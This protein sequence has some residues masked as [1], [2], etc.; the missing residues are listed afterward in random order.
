M[1]SFNVGNLGERFPYEVEEVFR[2]HEVCDFST[3]SGTGLEGSSPVRIVLMEGTLVMCRTAI[4]T[5]EIWRTQLGDIQSDRLYVLRP[6]PVGH[7][8]PK[9]EEIPL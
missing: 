3:E 8:G 5:F 9:G 1:A 7:V 4:V 6:D 2:Y